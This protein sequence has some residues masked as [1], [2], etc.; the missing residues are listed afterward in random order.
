MENAAIQRHKT[1]IRRG[2]FS[3]PVKC[4]LRDGLVGK[5]GTFFDYGCG[6]GEDIELLTAEGVAC[7]GWDPAY[8]PD[9]ARQ[10]AD[11]VNLGYVINV[12][13]DMAERA[14]TLRRAWE[15]A[16]QVLAVSAQVL[17]SGRGKEP[18]EFGDGVLTCR[19]TFQKF[20]EQNELKVYL[21]AQLQT[22]A[23]PAGIGTFYLFKDEARRQQF[24]ASRFRRRE[25]LPRRR[26]A[27]L[28]LEETRQLL[29]PLMEVI[30][31][32]GRVPDPLE[33]PEAPAIVERFGSLKR[34]FAA[35]Q[36]ITDAE[37]WEAIARRRREDM[38]V[39]LAL[40]RFR[41]RP[42]LSQLPLGLQRDMKAFFGTYNKACAEADALL[43]KA[44]DSAAIDDASK[45]STIG[46]LLPDDLY[47]HRS[48]IESLV[49]ILRIYEGCGQAY[50]GEVEGANVIKIHRRTG[51]LSYLSYPRF[52]TDPH[53]GLARCVKLNL[54]TRQIECYDYGQSAN[55]PVLHRKESFLHSDHPLR[56]KFA[57]LTG[58]EEKAGLLEDSSGIGTR[59]GWARRLTER[60]F[61]LK[62]HRLVRSSGRLDGPGDFR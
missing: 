26:V 8:R 14:E 48:A 51:K 4:L 27:E 37:S 29:E 60:G 12:I 47:V 35:I 55:P 32:L 38:L 5:E 54:R 58:Q 23:I 43:F 9:A 7:S 16:R 61:A 53:P 6:R 62:G 1:A 59:D 17:V 33:F 50:L 44:G 13:E 57:R 25:I 30:A 52:E 39:Y 11:V 3:R 18:I 40:A 24:L 2:D 45:R 19:N 10:E 34:A 15:L 42:L 41:K 28:R 20:Y 21:E 46:K 36:Q 22:E 31:T 49:P 56:E